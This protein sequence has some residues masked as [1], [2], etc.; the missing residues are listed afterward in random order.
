MNKNE[1]YTI[2]LSALRVFD[3]FVEFR[4]HVGLV[5]CNARDSVQYEL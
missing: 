4:R 3:S 2:A 5:R 1:I